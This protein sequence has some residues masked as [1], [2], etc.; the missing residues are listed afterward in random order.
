MENRPI[1]SSGFPVAMGC[2]FWPGLAGTCC[3]R[4]LRVLLH[5][6]LLGAL[7]LLLALLQHLLFARLPL[8]VRL[9]FLLL[10]RLILLGF[11]GLVRLV[12]LLT[13]LVALYL[14]LGSLLGLLL[15]S[16]SRSLGLFCGI[17]LCTGLGI[18]YGSGGWRRRIDPR[19][20]CWTLWLL[21]L[22]F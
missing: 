5:P 3:L 9:G 8:L 22:R 13:L 17:A 21:A 6:G 7:L 14:A 11:L 18:G 15:R 20:R 16:C 2:A 10:T 19:L 1:S 12:L 4:A